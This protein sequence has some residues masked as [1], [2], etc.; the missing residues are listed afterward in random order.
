MEWG[1]YNGSTPLRVDPN[2]IVTKK[3][4]ELSL[5]S[6][7]LPFGLDQLLL[8]LTWNIS[9]DRIREILRVST[10]EQVIE[11]KKKKKRICSIDSS[12]ISE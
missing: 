6:R 7:T 4:R 8:M 1:I 11:K 5:P 2:V 3:T 9:I 12:V 10:I